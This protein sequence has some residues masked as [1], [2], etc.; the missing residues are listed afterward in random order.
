RGGNSS[1]NAEWISLHNSCSSRRLLKAWTIKDAAG[2]T[3]TFGS[4]YRLGGGAYVRVHTGR[5]RNT[6]TDRYWGMSWYVWNNDAD[7]AYLHNLHGKLVDQCSYNSS[8]A[9]ST[10]C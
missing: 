5:G 6:R 4:S 7:T 9:S 2:H 3:Y 1:L 8:S 10:S